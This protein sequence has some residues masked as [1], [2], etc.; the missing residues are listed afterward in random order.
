MRQ[1]KNFCEVHGQPKR[2]TPDNFDLAVHN[3]FAGL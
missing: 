2:L 3:Y 1:I